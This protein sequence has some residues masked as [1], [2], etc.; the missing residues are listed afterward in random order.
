MPTQALSPSTETPCPQSQP[1]ITALPPPMNSKE[2]LPTLLSTQSSGSGYMGS[3]FM[4]E[5]ERV[6][7]R[8][9]I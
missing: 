3:C 5:P 9:P 2:K 8:P 6:P 4:S 1:Q 7:A